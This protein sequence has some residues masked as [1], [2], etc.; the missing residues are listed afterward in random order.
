MFDFALPVVMAGSI[1]IIYLWLGA[2]RLRPERQ[3][4]MGDSSSR[5]FEAWLHL[6]EDGLAHGKTN[7]EVLQKAGGMEFPSSAAKA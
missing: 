7:E 1:G 5:V 3:S 4:L 6:N 2:P